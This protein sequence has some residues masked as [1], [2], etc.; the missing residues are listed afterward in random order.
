M[1]FLLL[2]ACLI[3]ASLFAQTPNGQT[4]FE[5]RCA[6]CHQ[7]PVNDRIPSRQ[8]LAALQAA[9]VVDALEKGAMT[10]QAQGLSAAEI[11]ALATFVTGK[12]LPA[13]TAA[14]SAGQC[15]GNTRTFA[16]SA[17]DWNG[18]GMDTA[19]TRY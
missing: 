4:L 5:G 2:A 17:S 14:A 15:T 6:T 11:R 13:A 1:R 12:A 18:W 9:Q 8:A 7:A 16:P 19:N 10:T 3:P